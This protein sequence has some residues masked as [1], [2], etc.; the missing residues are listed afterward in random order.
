[1]LGAKP[2]HEGDWREFSF[3]PLELPV[4]LTRSMGPKQL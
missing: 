2:W 3:L 1:M 4:V